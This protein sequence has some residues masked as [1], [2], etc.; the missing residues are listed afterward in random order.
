MAIRFTAGRCWVMRLTESTFPR[1]PTAPRSVM[2]GG[3]S[4]M[5]MIMLR[6]TPED[7]EFTD[8]DDCRENGRLYPEECA[9]RG[10]RDSPEL[11]FLEGNQ[12]WII[13]W[14]RLPRR[15]PSMTPACIG[16]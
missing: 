11:H 7:Y 13:R 8:P 12:V 3:S 4:I 16:L 14:S 10:A 9:T 15:A 5:G 1:A 2:V 6:G